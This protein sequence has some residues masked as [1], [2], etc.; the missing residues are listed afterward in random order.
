MAGRG[1]LNRDSGIGNQTLGNPEEEQDLEALSDVSEDDEDEAEL[2][3]H[4][5]HHPPDLYLL[6]GWRSL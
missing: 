5:D 1:D 4:A 2:E 3:G 6:P